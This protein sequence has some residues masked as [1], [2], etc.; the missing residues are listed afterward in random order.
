MAELLTEAVA[1]TRKLERRLDVAGGWPEASQRIDF[2]ADP[3]AGVRIAAALLL[4]KARIHTVAVLRANETNNLHSLAVQMRP[5]LECAGQVVFYFHNLV[6]A[7]DLLMALERALEIL[8]NR[9]NADHYQTLRART[10]GKVSPEELREVEA[11]AEEAAAAFIGAPKPKRREGRR[12][13]QSDKVAMLQGGQELYRYLSDH[14]SHGKVANWRGL[15][16]QGG[17]IS[18]N[19]VEDEFAFLSSMDYLV[20]QVAIM[21]A[22]AAL[23]PVAGDADDLWDRWVEPTLARL[24]DVRQ[25]SK[26][27]RDATIGGATGGVDGSAR[28]G[29]GAA[30]PV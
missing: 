2:D 19:R 1:L 20:N 13:N 16:S 22:Y 18:I 17:V 3:A 15:S 12:L 27:L 23:C 29:R 6:I 11:Q 14:F 8:G 28:T 30:P 5:V 24:R 26:A 7:P 4:R 21:N 9:L 25:S 10:K